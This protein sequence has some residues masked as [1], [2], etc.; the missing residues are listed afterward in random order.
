ME[1]ER[2]KGS[3]EDDAITCSPLIIF[4]QT[5]SKNKILNPRETRKGCKGSRRWP[6]TTFPC[7]ETPD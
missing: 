2:A 1:R 3:K 7:K 5:E 6:E 4:I